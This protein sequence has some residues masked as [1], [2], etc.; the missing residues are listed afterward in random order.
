MI[1]S[2]MDRFGVDFPEEVDTEVK[3]TLLA[4]CFLIDYLYFEFEGGSKL[5]AEANDAP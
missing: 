2:E 3:A 1:P 5:E 4:A